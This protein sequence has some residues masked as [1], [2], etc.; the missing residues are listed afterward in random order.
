MDFFKKQIRWIAALLFVALTLVIPHTNDTSVIDFGALTTGAE[1]EALTEKITYL[2]ARLE[3]EGGIGLAVELGE[4]RLGLEALEY[5]RSALIT[6]IFIVVAAI[7]VGLAFSFENIRNPFWKF[8]R[9]FARPI[10]I[11][12]FV[13]LVVASLEIGVMSDVGIRSMFTGAE[14]RELESETERLY[15]ILAGDLDNEEWLYYFQAHQAAENRLTQLG[16][17]REVFIHGRIPRLLAVILSAAGLSVAGLLMQ[18]ISR[19]KFMSPT[20]AGTTD[21]AALGLLMGVVFFGTMPAIVQGLF[22]FGFALLATVIFTAVISRL[23]LREVV[24]IPLIGLLYGGLIGALST[25]I[26]FRTELTQVLAAFNMGSFARLGNFTL[27]YIVIVPLI[28]SV[29]FATKFSIIGLGEDFAKNL[30]VS[31]R[32]VVLLG[33][34]IVAL[35][36]ASTFVA[37]GPLPFIGLII[38]NMATSIYGDNLKKSIVDLMLFGAVFVMICDIISRLIIFPFEMM[39]SVTIAVVGGII[40]MIYLIRGMQSGKNRKVKA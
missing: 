21:A 26:A 37:V 3:I 29:I 2:D 34:V 32:R 36:A 19:N 16:N 40:F 38:P 28:V 10:T 15:E 4:A 13:A 6:R 27:V 11:V 7:A 31:Y 33:L 23:K 9:K 5:T 25:A 35:I 18:A 39:V 8:I 1:I 17:H 12:L 14:M 22:A 24:Y 20:T 30:G